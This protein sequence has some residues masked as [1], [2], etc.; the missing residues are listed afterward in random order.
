MRGF[1]YSMRQ[2]LYFISKTEDLI[3]FEKLFIDQEFL[4]SLF[5][6]KNIQIMYISLFN[7][8]KK[9]QKQNLTHFEQNEF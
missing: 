2:F 8:K 1:A 5:R 4:F 9:T 3:K 6:R 7:Q